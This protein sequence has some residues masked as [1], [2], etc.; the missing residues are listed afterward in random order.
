VWS[1]DEGADTKS[2]GENRNKQD[3]N[4][5]NMNASDPSGFDASSLIPRLGDAG[6]NVIVILTLNDCPVIT[7][8]N[9]CVCNKNTT[10]DQS[11]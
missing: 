9:D 11:S 4:Q 6:G 1:P 2:N 8:F 10:F 3:Y 7:L 5:C